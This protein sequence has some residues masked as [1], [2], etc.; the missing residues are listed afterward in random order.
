MSQIRAIWHAWRTGHRTWSDQM[1]WARREW[2]G[3]VLRLR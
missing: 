3:L 2:D 1:I